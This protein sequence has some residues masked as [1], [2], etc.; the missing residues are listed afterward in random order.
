[1]FSK[2]DYDKSGTLDANELHALFKENEYEI[3]KEKVR[4]LYGGGNIQISA[5]HLHQMNNNKND[6]KRFR[7]GLTEIREETVKKRLANRL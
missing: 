5:D 3:D 2:F 7:E 4:K 6:L 1:M